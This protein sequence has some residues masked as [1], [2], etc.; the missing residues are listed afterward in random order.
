V[1]TLTLTEAEVGHH[2]LPIPPLPAKKIFEERACLLVVRARNADNH[3][4]LAI[5]N[6][7][8]FDRECV[9]NGFADKMSRRK[10]A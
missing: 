9:T 7:A 2:I 4:D 5:I 6:R 3:L 1:L 8:S 10:K